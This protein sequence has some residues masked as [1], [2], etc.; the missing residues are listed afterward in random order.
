M[1]RPFPCI[2]L[3][4]ESRFNTFVIFLISSGPADPA[5]IMLA[6]STQ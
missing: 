6:L 4:S 1:V 2:A 5:P 3:A